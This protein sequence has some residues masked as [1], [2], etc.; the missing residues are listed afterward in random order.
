MMGAALDD[1]FPSDDDRRGV[2]TRRSHI[3][4]HFTTRNRASMADV[5][6]GLTIQLVANARRFRSAEF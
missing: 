3:H 4:H 6:D 2:V 5:S 1:L